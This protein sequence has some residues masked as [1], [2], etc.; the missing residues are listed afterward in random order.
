[1]SELV[2]Y[3]KARLSRCA[4][5][6]KWP[7]QA[8][9]GYGYKSHLEYKFSYD[10]SQRNVGGQSFSQGKINNDKTVLSQTMH[11]IYFLHI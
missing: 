7:G 11:V 9:W 6:L 3:P 5:H 1:M 8:I 4:V 10:M 2:G